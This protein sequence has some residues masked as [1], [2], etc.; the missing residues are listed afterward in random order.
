[1]VEQQSNWRKRAILFF[2]S[3]CI[4]LFGSQIV[5]MAIVWYVTLQTNSGLWVAA[6]SICSY[7]P[8]FFVSFLGGVLADRYN[9]KYL[10]IVADTLIATVTLLMLLIMPYITAE[11]MLL[12][13]LLIMS[14]VRSAGAGIQN[15]AVN[16]TIPQLVP[17]E[18]LMRY[19]GINATMQSVVQFAAPAVAA[20]VLSINTLRSTLGIDVVTALIGIGLF[21]CVRLPK[22]ELSKQTPSILADMGV[23]TRYAY[24]HKSI[25]KT[26]TI[27][28]LFVFFTVPAGYLSGLLVSR[29]YGDTYWYLTAV[30]LVGFGGMML[31]GLLMSVWGGFKSRRL[32]LAIA[33]LL[34]GA[35]A[36]GMGVS[37]FFYL[38]L[39]LMGL[40]GIALTAAQTTITT[41][42][43]EETEN[44]M[45]GRVFGL[46]SSLYSSCYPIG[47]LLF[48]PM[49]DKF[50]LQWIMIGS[51]IVLIILALIAYSEPKS[52]IEQ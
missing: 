51:G 35:M 3:Q 46:M 26:L 29:V 30:E 15:P 49:A 34:F 40:Y 28:G 50:S 11:P 42:L 47:M 5:Q 33:L 25:R 48:G 24:S 36:I 19:N 20:V 52:E 37:S 18:H 8:Q 39:V 2:T 41:M 10:I 16:A 44:T 23:G 21:L 13:T 12:T 14:I 38:Y 32:T 43:Q 6:F 4:S 7:L 17:E 22:Q 31:G 1:M 27:Y 9:R 45:Q